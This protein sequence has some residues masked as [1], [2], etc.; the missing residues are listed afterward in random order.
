MAETSTVVGPARREDWRYYV[1]LVSNSFATML[2]LGLYSLGAALAGLG[3]A[4][5]LAGLGLVD[6]DS[7]LSTG[8][9]LVTAMVLAVAGAFL[10]GIASE[11][12]ARRNNRA[13]VQNELERALARA[14]SSVLVGIVLIFAA[15]MLRPLVEDFPAPINQG[16][17]LMRKAG[18]AGLWPVPL[19][20][21][22][23]AWG[24]RHPLALGDA[25]I[26]LELPVMFTVWT[27]ALLLL[28]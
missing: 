15:G 20:G 28:N 12:P 19:I 17:E 27:L 7:G 9:G 25:G 13:F 1:R 26:E 23:L 4:L 16:V 24:I 22:P 5:A 11:G 8:S 2:D 6:R 3:I 18:I 21:V 14:L 10:M